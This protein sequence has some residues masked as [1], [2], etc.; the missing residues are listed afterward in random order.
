M[1]VL[2]CEL[3]RRTWK[4]MFK[5]FGS[6]GS[7]SRCSG[8]RWRSLPFSCWRVTYPAESSSALSSLPSPIPTYPLQRAHWS[9]AHWCKRARSRTRSL[10]R[11]QISILLVIFPLS[12]LQFPSVEKGRR[13]CLFGQNSDCWL[14][15]HIYALYSWPEHRWWTKVIFS[16]VSYQV[17]TD[18]LLIL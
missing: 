3:T 16:Y 7:C 1:P 11:L 5:P 13:G 6:Q 4:R 8:P 18:Y 15:T 12:G 14:I 9:V 2:P 17:S 10:T